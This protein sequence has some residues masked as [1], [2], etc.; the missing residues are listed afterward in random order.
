MYELSD[1]LEIASFTFDNSFGVVHRELEKLGKLTHPVSRCPLLNGPMRIR[2]WDS[3]SGW[4][5]VEVPLTRGVRPEA[6]TG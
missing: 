3:Q 5:W 6:H 4:T 1:D 2:R